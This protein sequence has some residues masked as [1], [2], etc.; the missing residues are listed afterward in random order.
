MTDLGPIP[1]VE[2]GEPV[3]ELQG[4]VEKMHERETAAGAVALQSHGA[5]GPLHRPQPRTDFSRQAK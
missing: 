5:K 4:G 3:L 1:R 2:I